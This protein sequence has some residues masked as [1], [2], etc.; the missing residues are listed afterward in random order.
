MYLILVIVIIFVSLLTSELLWRKKL[1]S[2]ETSR[3]LVHIVS[4][5]AVA[6]LPYYVDY[7]YIVALSVAFIIVLF[8]SSRFKLFKSIKQVKRRSIG[9]YTFALVILVCSLIS[10]PSFV[11]TIAILNL[12][13]ADG[14]AALIGE[15]YGKKTRYKVFNNQKSLVGSATFLI[16]SLLILTSASVLGVI[17]FSYLLVLMVILLLI[18]ENIFSHGVDNLIIPVIVVVFLTN[19]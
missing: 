10:P 12:A 2:A 16:V 17:T 13:L 4:G 5:V 1:V 14:F 19:L 9:E 11:F 8:L 6:F 18:A 3:K 7:D 15:K